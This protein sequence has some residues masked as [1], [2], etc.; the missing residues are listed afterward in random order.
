MSDY[1]IRADREPRTNIAPVALTNS[2]SGPWLRSWSNGVALFITDADG[3]M[4]RDDNGKYAMDP[5]YLAAN[6]FRTPHDAKRRWSIKFFLAGELKA[7]LDQ[8]DVWSLRMVR[9]LLAYLAADWQP[10]NTDAWPLRREL[11]DAVHAAW[12][13]AADREILAILA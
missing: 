11:A 9:Q 12:L 7:V 4:T 10:K 5:A 8:D 1:A 13:E 2:E 3:H 6:V